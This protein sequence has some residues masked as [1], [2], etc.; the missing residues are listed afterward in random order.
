MHNTHAEASVSTEGAV[1]FD[2]SFVLFFLSMDIASKGLLSLEGL[3][4]TPALIAVLLVPYLL[5]AGSDVSF[6]HWAA[7]RSVI[8]GFGLAIGLAFGAAVGTILPDA[9]SPLPFTF[10]IMACM[11]TVFLS[12]ASLLG[13]SFRS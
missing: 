13:W 1:E 6:G 3:L 12:F 8:A 4:M 7:G 9:L 2:T 11:A 10:L 5:V